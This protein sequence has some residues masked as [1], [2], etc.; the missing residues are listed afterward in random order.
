MIIISCPECRKHFDELGIGS[1]KTLETECRE[2]GTCFIIQPD[3]E[4]VIREGTASA[5]VD[6]LVEMLNTEARSRGLKSLLNLVGRATQIEDIPEMNE[7]PPGPIT[8]QERNHLKEIGRYGRLLLSVHPDT[9]RDELINFVKGKRRRIWKA[10]AVNPNAPP[11]V[12][13]ELAELVPKAFLRSPALDLF[14]LENPGWTPDLSFEAWKALLADP[15]VPEAWLRQKVERYP[16]AVAK[17]PNAPLNL[18]IKICQRYQWGARYDFAGHQALENP[19]FPKR[20]KSL[21]I[22]ATSSPDKIVDLRPVKTEREFDFLRGHRRVWKDIPHPPLTNEERDHLLNAASFGRVETDLTVSSSAQTLVTEQGIKALCE[23]GRGGK[24]IAASISATPRVLR[25]LAADEVSVRRCV[26]GN[27]NAPQDLLAE[28]AADEDIRVREAVATNPATSKKI[29]S[30][31]AGDLSSRVRARLVPHKNAP[32]EL[33]RLMARAGSRPGLTGRSD[34]PPEPITDEERDRL[35]ALGP[36]GQDLVAAHPDTAPERLRALADDHPEA[37]AENPSA[38][39]D[40]LVHLATRHAAEVAQNPFA[41]EELLAHL[42]SDEY[43]NAV[44]EALAANPATPAEVLQTLR[45][46]DLES[47]RGAVKANPAY[48]GETSV[49][50]KTN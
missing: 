13:D 39:D 23:H 9:P 6:N 36:Y 18:L 10:V 32:G 43:G 25:D 12:F 16:R 15:E 44:H 3:S 5:D 20:L 31:L 27:R 19:S 38:P 22:H 1:E 34:E 47:V 42:A 49:D 17:N 28:L 11:E 4:I 7:W 40:L 33:L 46:H 21:L 41:P 35:L 29:L 26:A 2:C 48:S 45:H 8:D 37:V 30:Q 14:L 24:R 50:A